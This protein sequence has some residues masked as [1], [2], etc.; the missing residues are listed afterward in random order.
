MATT[1]KTTMA[2]IANTSAAK[3]GIIDNCTSDRLIL[4]GTNDCYRL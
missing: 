3:H 1:G 4:N 2:L